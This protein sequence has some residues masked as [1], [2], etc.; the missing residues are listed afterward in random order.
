MKFQ[1]VL[2]F[3]TSPHCVCVC[4]RTRGRA[5]V[6]DVCVGVCDVCGGRNVQETILPAQTTA[7]EM[8]RCSDSFF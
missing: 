3:S 8:G 5:R 4:V 6:G 2:T 1:A 7:T